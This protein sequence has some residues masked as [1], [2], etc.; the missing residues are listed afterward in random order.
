[1]RNYCNI[2]PGVLQDA[3]QVQRIELSGASATRWLSYD[4]AVQN[5]KKAYKA[6]LLS[7]E[8]EETERACSKAHGHLKHIRAWRHVYT[9]E[10]LSAILPQLASL[11]KSFQVSQY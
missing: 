7:L 3:L 4:K 10:L 9:V 6:V 2:V 11:S 8:R 1:M 5:M